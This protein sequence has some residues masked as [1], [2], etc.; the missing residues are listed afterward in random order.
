MKC[1]VRGVENQHQKKRF[2]LRKMERIFVNE[3]R[4]FDPIIHD[5]EVKM[6]QNVCL[7]YKVSFIL[8]TQYITLNINDFIT[9]NNYV[10]CSVHSNLKRTTKAFYFVSYY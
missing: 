5:Q 1:I 6:F 7:N 8:Q 2:N 4:R 10:K 9:S 3:C